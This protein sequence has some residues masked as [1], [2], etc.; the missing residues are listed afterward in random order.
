[1]IIKHSPNTKSRNRLP[2]FNKLVNTN[3]IAKSVRLCPTCRFQIECYNWGVIKSPGKPTDILR[4]A[5]LRRTPVRQAV[6]EILASEKQPLGAAQILERLPEGTDNVTLYRTLNTF[7]KKKLVHRVRGDDQVWRYG[8]GN[9]KDPSRHEHAHFVCD[10]CGTVECLAD[11]PVPKKSPKRA[12][13]RS[14]YRVAYSEVLVHGTC[15]DCHR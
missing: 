9:A 3:Q 15:P 11:S 4:D 10:E 7:T 6:L 13:L 2:K 14:G 12:G 1:M 8:I 5:G